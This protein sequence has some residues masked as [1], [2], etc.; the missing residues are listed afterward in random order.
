MKPIYFPFTYVPHWIA[1]A[2]TACFK[3]FIIYQPSGQ[4]LPDGM[5]NWVDKKAM[6][7]QV[8]VQTGD[9]KLAKVIKDFQSFARLHDDR[10]NLKT[11]ALLGQEFGLP[12]FGESASS[13]IVSDVKKSGRPES[14]NVKLDSSFSAR[15][16]LEFAQQFDRQTDELNQGLG[17]SDRRSQEML[18]KL[19]GETDKAIPATP[20]S[21][22]NAVYDPG[23]Y[24]TTG[25]L[26]AWMRLF[27]KEPA[28]SGLF[29]TSSQAVLNLLIES[30]TTA[31]KVIQLEAIP[32]TPAKGADAAWRDL[33]FKKINQLVKKK[34]SPADHTFDDVP[35]PEG[36]GLNVTLALYLIPGQNPEELFC[37]VFEDQNAG[38]IQTKQGTEFVNTLFG[39][40]SRKSVNL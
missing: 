32:P 7:V 37:R 2:L 18:N 12:F 25:R 24:L 1:E 22:D 5:Q 8:P 36:Q 14:A 31:E 28:E 33:F 34:W 3:Q 38:V 4:Q 39:L 11:A 9:E 35:L 10:K 30:L 20:L 27:M 26:Q 13:R 23:E 15:V 40:I 19:S 29:V 21:A 6:E 17:V 16:F